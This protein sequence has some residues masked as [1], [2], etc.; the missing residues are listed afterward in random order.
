MVNALERHV[1]LDLFSVPVSGTET[2]SGLTFKVE[3]GWL[4]HDADLSKI[5]KVNAIET[6]DVVAIGG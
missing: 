4:D 1:V 2:Y 3:V 5:D 6:V